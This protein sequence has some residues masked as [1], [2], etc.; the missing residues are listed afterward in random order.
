M[1]PMGLVD[2]PDP[3]EAERGLE[4]RRMVQFFIS[5]SQTVH[6]KYDQLLKVVELKYLN[7]CALCTPLLS[8][9]IMIWIFRR[10]V[11]SER[12]RTALLRSE[13]SKFLHLFLDFRQNWAWAQVSVRQNMKTYPSFFVMKKIGKGTYLFA[14]KK[15]MKSTRKSEFFS[16]F[17]ISVYK[18]QV[19]ELE[20]STRISELRRFNILKISGKSKWLF[21]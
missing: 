7:V 16:F 15:K 5:L 20:K 9:T 1:T 19:M 10:S 4:H 17:V 13:P 21:E 3:Q 18:Q 2:A 6:Y 8:K 11:R 14:R 12:P